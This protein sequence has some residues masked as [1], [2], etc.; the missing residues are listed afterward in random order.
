MLNFKTTFTA[1]ILASALSSTVSYA[2]IIISGTRIIY[3]ENKKDISVRLENKGTRPLLVQNWIDLGNDSANPESI[4]APF[5]STPPVS[6]VEP[7]R[8]QSVKIVYTQAQALPKDRESVFWF[9]VLEVPPKA[10]TSKEENK[11]LLQLAFR[12]RIKLFYRPSSLPGAPAEAPQKLKW[13][14]ASE[15][16]H[17]VVR[18]DNP[19]PYYVSFNDATFA[20]GGKRYDVN[21]TMV[22]P[23]SKASFTVKGLQHPASGKLEYHAINDFGGI[24]EGSASL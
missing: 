23:F 5:I 20:V 6:R 11:N 18:A 8:G 14:I 19:T 15:Q 13:Q 1:I 22:A 12:T 24:I 17:A 2:D 10:D 3:D 9:N 7:K 16:G 21:A 4:K